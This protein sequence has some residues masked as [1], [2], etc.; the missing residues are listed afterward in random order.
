VQRVIAADPQKTL[1]SAEPVVFFDR[2]EVDNLEAQLV[3]AFEEFEVEDGYEHPAERLMESALRQNPE[4]KS[5]LLGLFRDPYFRHR[6]AL[7]RCIGR[8]PAE[9][10][11]TW[12]IGMVAEAL[13]DSDL[14]LRDAAL[15][16]IEH[17]ETAEAMTLIR[18]YRDPH[19]WL[20]Q[21]VGRI[22]Q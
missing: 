3:S 20:E 10:A 9:I 12:G 16:A 14:T 6:T 1:L 7:L 22:R 13:Q 11:G 19:P 17:W 5:T 15:R 2:R 4:T 8:L 21:Y 18:D